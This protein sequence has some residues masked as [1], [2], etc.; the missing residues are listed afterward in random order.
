M[1]A[2]FIGL[3]V[4]IQLRAG[5]T[6]QGT[7]AAVDGA[8]GTIQLADL[9]ITTPEGSL[10]EQ[11][12]TFER[13][14]V[15]GLQ[16]LDVKK[17][18]PAPPCERLAPPAPALAPT[19]QAQT[20]HQAHRELTPWQDDDLTGSASHASLSSP[21]S[22][23][24]R[25]PTASNWSLTV[26]AS[27]LQSASS[28][29]HAA[30]LQGH[31]Y[32]PSPRASPQASPKPATPRS[33]KRGTRGGAGARRNKVHADA[34]DG[35]GGDEAEEAPASGQANQRHAA[36]PESFDEEFDFGAGLRSFDK[37]AVFAHIR[38]QDH[39]DPSLRLV[40]HNRN[41]ART[42]TPQS[43][44]LPTESVL[45]VEEL[46]S[47]QLDRQNALGVAA[48][49]SRGMTVEELEAG[50]TQVGLRRPSSSRNQSA[51]TRSVETSDGIV[52][53]VVRLKQWKEAL[54]I[55]DIETSP[56]PFQRLEMAA[57][58]LFNFVL[59][60][61]A[62]PSISLS[63][64]PA[65]SRTRP[66][67]LLLCTDCEKANVALRAGILLAHRGCRVVALVE[68]G[69]TEGLKTNLR[70]LSSA[71]GRIVRDVDDLPSTFNFVIDALADSETSVAS[72]LSSSVSGQSP[73]SPSLGPKA[74]FAPSVFA[75]E[76]AKWASALDDAAAIVSIDVPFGFDHDSG[77]ALTPAALE[78]RYIVSRALPRP[79]AVALVANAAC[80]TTP[81]LYVVDL[82]F[83]PAMWDRIGVEGFDL[84]AWGS[85]GF[86]ECHLAS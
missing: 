25:P 73:A 53:P 59:R 66:S 24:T 35:E 64:R 74:C 52:V 63:T 34:Y 8:A 83:A 56:S 70:I 85:D 6:A 49:S 68:D 79:G 44:L 10:R 33:N 13:S 67:V 38:S 61:H 11:R 80:A 2:S 43:K 41:P 75:L 39:I 45:T 84:T 4:L 16:V 48:S 54:S 51:S 7:V 3:P 15:A 72:S 60:T 32:G 31:D 82:G 29:Y 21:A 55:A 20:T 78:P 5:G 69:K 76:A 37:T 47:Q 57:Y 22:S 12:R 14:D 23:N 26:D 30:S 65:S 28:R 71:G 86:C 27:L 18:A 50:V 46:E 40:A 62:L 81:R 42:R 1:A 17:P 77:S 36:A 19:V 58:E 9:L